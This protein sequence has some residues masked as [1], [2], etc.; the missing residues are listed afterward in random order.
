MR[1]DNARAM[2]TVINA[3]IANPQYIESEPDFIDLL[4]EVYEPKFGD[5]LN[6][7]E[8]KHPQ[9]GTLFRA[10]LVRHGKSDD[11]I[12][13]EE[14][15]EKYCISNMKYAQSAFTQNNFSSAPSNSG[16]YPQ[17]IPFRD[18]PSYHGDKS[19]RGGLPFC[20][21]HGFYASPTSQYDAETG[22]A[23]TR[24]DSQPFARTTAQ[25]AS[26]SEPDHAAPFLQTPHFE[27]A[28]IHREWNADGMTT[29]PPSYPRFDRTTLH[30]QSLPSWDTLS[31]RGRHVARRSSLFPSG[32]HS[33]LSSSTME[34]NSNAFG[35]A[36]SLSPV[37]DL[38]AAAPFEPYDVSSLNIPRST[39]R[40]YSAQVSGQNRRS[41]NRQNG[42]QD[43]NG[44]DAP[45]YPSGSNDAFRRFERIDLMRQ[46]QVGEAY[47]DNA[48]DRVILDFDDKIKE[49]PKTAFFAAS[50]T[51]FRSYSEDIACAR[52]S[53]SSHRAIRK[54]ENHATMAEQIAKQTH[55]LSDTP[56]VE[57]Y[58]NQ[59]PL[60][61]SVTPP[62]I[63]TCVALCFVCVF[64]LLTYQ[65][66]KPDLEKQ[67]LHGISAS[68]IDAQETGQT[69]LGT[70]SARERS[71]RPA[72]VDPDW[73]TAYDA[74][75]DTWQSF[76][77]VKPTDSPSNASNVLEA[78]MA[79]PAHDA[80][81]PLHAA[82]VDRRILEGNLEEA[83]NYFASIA[84]DHEI[85]KNH[86]YFKWW[87]E[88]AI[89]NANF[90][91]NRAS[92]L[93]QKLL[94]TP[95]A[96][97]ALTQLGTLAIEDD[98]SQTDAK[99]AF[100]K[101]FQSFEPPQ[102][103]GESRAN[104]EIPKT[105]PATC[106]YALLTKGA[107]D[108]VFSRAL[109]SPY[110]D[111]CAAARIFSKL[112]KGAFGLKRED[113]EDLEKLE[114]THQTT[115][116]NI[117]VTE[118]VILAEIRLMHPARA[119]KFFHAVDLPDAHPQKRALKNA[120]FL[121]AFAFGNW[122][123]LHELSPKSPNPIELFDALR[124]IDS[125]QNRS[126]FKPSPARDI[127]FMGKKPAF[128]HE[129]SDMDAIYR[130]AYLGM[131]AT[132]LQ[133]VRSTHIV[134][135]HYYESLAL[136]S[137]ILSHMGKNREAARVLSGD[138][139][140][141]FRSV[142]FIV[143][144]NMYRARA[145]HPLGLQAFILPFVAFEDPI[146]EAARCEVFWRKRMPQAEAC[147]QNLHRKTPK[148]K[149]QAAWIMA[150]LKHPDAF[151]TGTAQEWANADA[152]ALAFPSFALAYAR[153]LKR[154]GQF[155]AA[156]RQYARALI[157]D[158]TTATPQTIQE[159]EEAFRTH[160]QRRLIAARQFDAIIPKA[161]AIQ[162]HP[163]LIGLMHL[164]A[165][166]LYQPKSANAMVK[167]HLNKAIEKL[168]ETPEI[169]KQFVAYYEAKDKPETA[170]KYK[171]KL[172]AMIQSKN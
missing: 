132:A 127:F 96:P 37:K 129:M 8:A 99:Q 38:P 169:L 43:A 88:A 61:F 156:A 31:P 27:D 152:K 112:Q 139:K 36:T 30:S 83:A 97:F 94:Y 172:S 58:T 170:L 79:K 151:P 157:D 142:P 104:P 72:F 28:R 59:H 25:G 82:Y 106:A 171:K 4:A 62:Q 123:I 141:G 163:T 29:E 52:E 145:N 35:V 114:T 93:Y 22:N 110:D 57:P 168:G 131:L 71:H 149:T 143:L 144:S 116:S 56:S 128:H 86:A 20:G 53:N 126:L 100:L 69:P 137:M 108:V 107:Q 46:T 75:L 138:F 85:W 118:A 113:F 92:S 105:I 41:E 44:T 45:T 33:P 159:F 51:K 9:F 3:L 154:E 39:T 124:M 68:Y 34:M 101:A 119:A 135:A 47:A 90:E 32:V 98:F 120:I 87:I 134:S 150:H 165:A 63:L 166:R 164:T 148:S 155:T 162:M 115:L 74:F 2:I 1:G 54:Q 64:L 15:F 55:E 161:E 84:D 121:E 117:A 130:D 146:L 158:P 21:A 67:A 66:A 24:L 140:E 167:I 73:L 109:Q 125:A 81:P 14:E 26:F 70:S 153:V 18:I 19:S 133:E 40:R 17:F 91:L 102:G 23:L 136:Q 13:R 80:P 6:S 49:T 111:Y 60:R 77:F 48:T 89:A 7:I 65:A 42:F 76:Y 160:P 95:L 10:A 103:I 5:E 147:I 78:E 11:A 12:S 50:K 122:N 16:L